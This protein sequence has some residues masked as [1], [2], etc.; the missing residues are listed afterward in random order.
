MKKALSYINV[1]EEYT[2][3]LSLLALAL[4]SCFQVLTRYAFNY[5][6][7]WFEELSRYICIFITFLGA[8]LGLKYGS[9]FTMSAL[10]DRLPFRARRLIA[11]LV[12]LVSAAFFVVVTYY[13]AVHCL[14]HY[15]YGNLS[16]AL[17][18]PMYLPYLPIPAFSALM[19]GRSLLQVGKDLSDVIRGEPAPPDM[20][21]SVPEDEPA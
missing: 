4:F 12:G 20:D 9:H 6:F 8:S 15:R 7:T 5:S 16:A 2:L 3:G 19:A 14:K 11:A 10:V 17:R 21:G 13:G 1:I 18:L